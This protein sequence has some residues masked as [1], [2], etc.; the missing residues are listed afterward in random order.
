MLIKEKLGL[1][2]MMGR[3]NP[4]PEGMS[5]LSPQIRAKLA[6]VLGADPQIYV[7]QLCGLPN[8]AICITY[9]RFSVLCGSATAGQ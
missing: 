9:D 5:P 1:C 2:A 3:D 7:A 4:E 6:P 8:L